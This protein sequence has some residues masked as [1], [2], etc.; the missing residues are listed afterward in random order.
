MKE[1]IT[2]IAIADDHAILRKGLVQMINNFNDLKVEADAANGQELIE[3][4]EK[5]P[6]AP[7]VLIL[8]INMPVMD[9]FATAQTVHEK[10]PDI[11]IIALSM[12]DSEESII[13]ML[14]SGASGYVLKDVDPFEL[15][16]AIRHLRTNEY[17]HS[18]LV[19]GTLL[20]KLNQPDTKPE[21]TEKEKTFLQYCCTEMTYR[22][23]AEKMFLSPRTI[24]GYREGLFAKL[25][26]NTRVGL[27]LY[28]IKVGLVK[29]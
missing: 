12:Y 19:S 27:A 8:D 5:L 4:I 14:R 20:S 1:P 21:L 24:D 26:V 23:I 9:G 2:R 17:Y 29:I 15:Y 28:A 13:K 18:E 25:N 16:K 7:D 11:K 22:E 10:W 3:K 6:S